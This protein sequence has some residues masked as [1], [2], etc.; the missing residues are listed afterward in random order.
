M[1]EFCKIVQGE[2]EPYI[3]YEDEKTMAFLDYDPINTGHVL[4]IPK[5]HYL[6]ADEMP[7]ELLLHLTAVSR[8]LLQAIKATFSPYG[9]TIMQNGGACN[10]IGHY[11]MHIFPR[12]EGD[13][14]GWTDSERVK[15][16]SQEIAASIRTRL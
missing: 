1:C 4:L 5:E 9:Y 14:F 2:I 11:H 3:V 7:E 16:Y 12:Y 6:D 15:K 10:E 13:G 8:K